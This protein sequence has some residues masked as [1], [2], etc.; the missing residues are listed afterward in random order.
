MAAAARGLPKLW[1]AFI[2][3]Y[4]SHDAY[5][6]FPKARAVNNVELIREILRVLAGFEGQPWGTVKAKFLRALTAADL[7]RR[8]AV[9]QTEADKL[10]MARILKVTFDNLGVAWIDDKD[11]VTLTLAGKAF[12][13]AADAEI[14][15]RQL[16]RYQIT[17][18]LWGGSD[19]V[20][21][22]PHA[23]LVEVMLG[24][25]RILSRDEFILFVARARVRDELDYVLEHISA[26]RKLDEQTQ[27]RVKE[28][29]DAIPLDKTTEDKTMLNRV[30]LDAPYCLA[31]HGL[32]SYTRRN[33]KVNEKEYALSISR[34]AER[35]LRQRLDRFHE[36]VVFIDYETAKDWMAAY[37]DL[38][39]N[40]TRSEAVEYYADRS[41]VEKAVEAF[42]MLPTEAREGF[43]EEEYRSIQ[44]QEKNLEDMLEGD[45][46]LLGDTLTLVKH[47]RQYE[48]LVG[49]I[50][51]LASEKGGGYV[52]IELKKGRAA[53]KVFGQLC[54]YM[55]FI[56]REVA[57][58]V[59]VRGIIVGRE[60]DK[61]LLYAVEA[62]PEGLVTLKAFDFRLAIQNRGLTRK[63]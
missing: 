16:W 29:L 31:F 46:K 14:F 4:V 11:S 45:V 51:L 13:E 23:F 50:D 18:P 3:D 32:A 41:N 52:V 54:R 24:S 34:L 43:T 35:K 48:T 56:K 25:D 37:G 30:R 49:P 62:V 2:S 26:W 44:I 36:E 58:G 63:T 22:F 61:K 42:M 7:F 60:I 19:E 20:R 28:E 38:E 5:W 59:P 10:A 27:S 15:T 9:E 21:L 39:S 8:H 53:D 55:G 17:N 40:S 47:G 1:K 33:A 57:N 6:Y 12:I